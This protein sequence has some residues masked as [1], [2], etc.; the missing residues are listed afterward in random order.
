MVSR[1]V[2][3]NLY[4]IRGSMAK[5]RLVVEDKDLGK[6]LRVVLG[7]ANY[8]FTLLPLQEHPV[9]QLTVEHPDKI[10]IKKLLERA[11]IDVMTA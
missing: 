1:T 6:V 9:F 2:V 5:T 3:S 11:S 7:T 10:D 8:S 4:V